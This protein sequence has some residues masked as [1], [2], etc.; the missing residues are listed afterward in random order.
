[1]DSLWMSIV[2]SIFARIG[3]PRGATDTSLI[4]VDGTFLQVDPSD[5][6]DFGLAL[7]A[8]VSQPKLRPPVSRL[9]ADPERRVVVVDRQGV[10]SHASRRYVREF[11]TEAGVGAAGKVLADLHDAGLAGERLELVRRVLARGEA[12]VAYQLLNGRRF[13]LMFMPVVEGGQ[14]SRCVV[15]CCHTTVG[16]SLLHPGGPEPV[17]CSVATLGPL[18]MLTVREL[19]V[20]R[21]LGLGQRRQAVAEK[22]AGSLRDMQAVVRSLRVKLAAR[23]NFAVAIV[24]IRLGLI[25]FEEAEWDRLLFVRNEREEGPGRGSGGAASGV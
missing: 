11:A 7:A 3:R 12:L 22:L 16:D 19:D 10:V 5:D 17:T 9:T 24:A 25:D 18:S 15:I 13:R 2:L 14:A 23:D 21:E 4:L 6:A 20:L 1:M 8:S